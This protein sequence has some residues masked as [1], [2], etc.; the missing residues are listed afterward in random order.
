MLN[1]VFA[2]SL[3][4]IAFCHGEVRTVGSKAP[5]VMKSPNQLCFI[6]A[7]PGE[8]HIQV[9]I[10]SMNIMQVHNIRLDSFQ[11]PNHPPG[12]SL[13]IETIIAQNF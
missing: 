8:E 1:T 12:Y 5:A 3:P 13:G 11:F 7:E 2:A 10:M 6:Q 9:T 4:F